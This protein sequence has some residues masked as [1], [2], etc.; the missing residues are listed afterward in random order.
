MAPPGYDRL[1]TYGCRTRVNMTAQHPCEGFKETH[2]T[3]NSTLRKGEQTYPE[4]ITTY[5]SCYNTNTP[6]P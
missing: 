4:L 1:P 3:R 6:P 2:G 5:E